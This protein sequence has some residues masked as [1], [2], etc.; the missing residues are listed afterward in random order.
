M[1]SCRDSTAAGSRAYQEGMVEVSLFHD[2]VVAT[3][4][5]TRNSLGRF[6][7]QVIV[8][9]VISLTRNGCPL[10]VLITYRLPPGA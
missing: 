1:G 3:Y 8:G 5:F 7:S 2:F 10:V 9:L 4:Q 6:S